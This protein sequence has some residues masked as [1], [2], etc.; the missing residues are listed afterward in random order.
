MP[1]DDSHDD[2]MATVQSLRQQLASASNSGFATSRLT[3]ALVEARTRELLRV[4]RAENEPAP[5]VDQAL[6]LLRC[7]KGNR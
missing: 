5:L 4:A 1:H 3:A 6:S 2:L 7:V